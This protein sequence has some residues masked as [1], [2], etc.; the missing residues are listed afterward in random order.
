MFTRAVVSEVKEKFVVSV[1]V[2]IGVDTWRD[3][4]N[5]KPVSFCDRSRAIEYAKTFGEV[6]A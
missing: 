3:S 1:L 6:V 5:H 2:R 4:R